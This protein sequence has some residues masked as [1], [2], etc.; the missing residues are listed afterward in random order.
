[1]IIGD[2]VSITGLT[3][4]VGEVQRNTTDITAREGEVVADCTVHTRLDGYFAA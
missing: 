4:S 2:A 3:S 1:M